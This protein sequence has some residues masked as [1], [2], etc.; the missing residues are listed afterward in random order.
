MIRQISYSL[1]LELSCHVAHRFMVRI[2]PKRRAT[3]F[4]DNTKENVYM[5]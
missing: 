2:R 4:Y 5:C 3:R 1:I